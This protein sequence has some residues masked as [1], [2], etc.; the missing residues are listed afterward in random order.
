MFLVIFYEMKDKMNQRNRDNKYYLSTVF[1]LDE[2]IDRYMEGVYEEIIIEQALSKE[3]F[4]E[5]I[6]NELERSNEPTRITLKDVTNYPDEIN[7]SDG[8]FSEVT[9]SNSGTNHRLMYTHRFDLK[10][11][12]SLSEAPFVVISDGKLGLVSNVLEFNVRLVTSNP[13]EQWINYLPS[14]VEKIKEANGFHQSETV[15]HIL[16]ERNEYIYNS[17]YPDALTTI[18]E[19]HIAKK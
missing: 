2:S 15:V 9:F 4:L 18:V 13:P 6:K 3:D 10:P 12:E 19:S 7:Q 8:E 17:K 11:E 14:F 16:S 1:R 5:K